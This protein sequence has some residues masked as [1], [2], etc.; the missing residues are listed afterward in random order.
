MGNLGL[1]FFTKIIDD[2]VVSFYAGLG[3]VR[4]ILLEDV[5]DSCAHCFTTAQE[6][7]KKNPFFR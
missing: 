7:E 4:A 6:K 5:F 3:Q 2:A 1:D